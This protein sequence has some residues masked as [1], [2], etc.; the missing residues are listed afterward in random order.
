MVGFILGHRHTI[1]VYDAAGK[2]TCGPHHIPNSFLI[3]Y[4]AVSSSFTQLLPNIQP[5]FIHILPIILPTIYP[6]FDPKN[7][8]VAAIFTTK[9]GPARDNDVPAPRAPPTRKL[10]R[11]RGRA[12]KMLRR[13]DDKSAL[14]CMSQIIYIYIYIYNIIYII[15]IIIL[16]M[17]LKSY[18]A[19]LIFFSTREK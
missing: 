3:I 1:T 11:F 15:I 19:S 18:L 16:D 2:R 4:P 10:R 13:R 14:V 8:H 17:R 5:T 12:S 7:P 6:S 9:A